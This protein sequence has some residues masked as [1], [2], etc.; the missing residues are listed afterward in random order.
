[1][2][3]LVK[4][5]KFDKKFVKER[6]SI[7]VLE[8][9]LK[10][11]KGLEDQRKDVGDKG[12]T[13]IRKRLDGNT[14]A[15][16]KSVDATYK[17]YAKSVELIDKLKARQISRRG[18]LLNWFKKYI[19]RMEKEEFARLVAKYNL[20]LN[21]PG[22]DDVTYD[23][24][25]V[26]KT[27]FVDAETTFEE[28]KA[29]EKKEASAVEIKAEKPEEAVQQVQESRQAEFTL[30]ESSEARQEGEQQVE[31]KEEKKKDTSREKAEKFLQV[32]TS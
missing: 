7:L 31:E 27:L 17:Q 32:S 4:K 23:E 3:R 25:L 28:S 2:G 20:S 1:M 15:V 22:L 13:Q 21:V 6:L 8:E 29:E 10:V 5:S 12:V 24:E 9:N 30:L 16:L 14:D 18:K 11:Y 19:K 26:F